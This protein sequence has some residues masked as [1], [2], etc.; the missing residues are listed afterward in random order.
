M[1][2]TFKA[3]KSEL[4]KAICELT[5]TP[6]MFL[7]NPSKDFTRKRKLSF[8]NVVTAL[9]SMSGGSLNNEL[10]NIFNY[11]IASP[12]VSAFVQQR[13]KIRHTAFEAL[14]HAFNN[15]CAS[16]KIYKGLRLLAVDGSD[17]HIP[18]DRSDHGSYY[19][20]S[21]G[22]KPYN[23]L[24]LNALYDLCDHTYV[25][26]LIQKR[27]CSNEHKAFVTMVDRTSL[28]VPVLFVAD[29]GFESYNNMAHVQ[30]AGAYFLIRI[31]DRT[32]GGIACSID[33]PDEDEFD[34]SCE[35]LLTRKQSA[36]GKESG[37]KYLPH[38]IVFDFLPPRSQKN[39]PMTP[40]PLSVRF[41]RLKTS[42][43]SYELLATN[44]DAS[45]FPPDELKKLYA[46]RWGIETSFRHLKYSLGLLHFHSKK[47]EYILQ[48]IFAKLT[49]Y[50]F[51]E[52]ITSLVV[53][54]K[55]HRKLSYKANF[56]AAIHICR[57][58]LLKNVSPFTLEALISK[59]LL[60]FRPGRSAPRKMVSSH[61]AV[62]F[63]YRLA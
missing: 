22:Q 33:L 63:I 55:K 54:Q 20:G 30:N 1:P 13:A 50:N 61:K 60:P 3:I 4:Q 34:V 40:F 2:H 5:L 12:S 52:L 6:E 57:N 31:K 27:R 23:L 18:T 10:M 59:H 16:K 14:F 28:D 9:L 38:N 32:H 36:S 11:D 15:R 35:L 7:K 47:T 25:D 53:I 56:S 45:S 37:E 51:A 49:M 19:P 29:R 48:E 41:V 62:S 42:D 58:F 24:H 43:N 8:E 44:L 21:N 46:L 39:V 26:A 17:L